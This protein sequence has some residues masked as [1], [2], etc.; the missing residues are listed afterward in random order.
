MNFS[1]RRTRPFGL[2]LSKPALGLPKG[3]A[4]SPFDTGPAF[5]RLRAIVRSVP[6]QGERRTRAA[7]AAAAD[8]DHAGTR[9]R[10]SGNP[11]FL[12]PA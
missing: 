12:K 4:Q 11:A 5:D 1:M 6:A 7:E 2:S 8:N 3:R 9:A 10:H